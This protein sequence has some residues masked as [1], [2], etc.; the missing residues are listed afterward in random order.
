MSKIE[1]LQN[2]DKDSFRRS[3]VRLKVNI[4]VGVE[5]FGNVIVGPGPGFEP[6]ASGS[7]VR[8]S[9]QA[10]L[11]GPLCPIALGCQ[12]TSSLPHF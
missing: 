10:E 5:A 9:N 7:T 3:T 1:S 12:G 8:R 11:P 2:L 4:G 6:G